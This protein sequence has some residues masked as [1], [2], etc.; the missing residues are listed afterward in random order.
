MARKDHNGFEFKR[1]GQ[2]IKIS[3]WCFD[4]ALT[5]V[6]INLFLRLK[7]QYKLSS[8]FILT[9]N[10]THWHDLHTGPGKE[11]WI[12]IKTSK[13]IIGNDLQSIG[14]VRFHRRCLNYPKRQQSPQLT[15]F[16]LL[17]SDKRYISIRCSTTR[18]Q[19]GF[20]LQ[21]VRLFILHTLSWK[22]YFW[23]LIIYSLVV[24]VNSYTILC[25]IMTVTIYNLDLNLLSKQSQFKGLHHFKEN[26]IFWSFEKS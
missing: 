19:S 17:P 23:D 20:C 9:G 12:V 4:L 15:L 14:E 5:S 8:V 16:T 21:A 22:V 18:I 10:I 2:K 25:C 7:I 6:E 11:W 26:C 1:P 24:I 13:V 3:S